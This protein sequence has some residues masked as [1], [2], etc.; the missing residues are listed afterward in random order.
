MIKPVLDST[1]W[2]AVNDYNNVQTDLIK[3][4]LRNCRWTYFGNKNTLSS[5]LWSVIDLDSDEFYDFHWDFYNT[6]TVEQEKTNDHIRSKLLQ[7]HRIYNPDGCKYTEAIELFGSSFIPTAADWEDM[8]TMFASMLRFDLHKESLYIYPDK[9]IDTYP[10]SEFRINNISDHLQFPE[11]SRPRMAAYF[12]DDLDLDPVFYTQWWTRERNTVV[13]I[14]PSR[15]YYK[16]YNFPPDR[17]CHLALRIPEEY[18]G[19]IFEKN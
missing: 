15:I 5:C 2:A 7:I 12:L 14:F 1:F 18:F 13:E 17:L 19:V 16:N 4:F 11:Y 6:I 10:F 9:T 8:T 3:K